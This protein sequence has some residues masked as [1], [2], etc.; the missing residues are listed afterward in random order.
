MGEIKS[1]WEIAREKAA[2]LGELSPEER[3]QQR[4]DRCS[5]IGKALAEQYLSQHDIQHLEA[6]FSKYN[7]EE[8]E[9]ITQA[10]LQRLTEALDLRYSLTLNTI[11]QGVLILIKTETV[12]ETIAKIR[13]LFQE[14]RETEEREKQE[15]ERTGM[16]ILH[17]LRISGT[18]ISQINIR[19]KEE[20][21]KKLLELAQPFNERLGKLKQELLT[22]IRPCTTS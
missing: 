19:A 8:R 21:Q 7:G 14:Y 9:L 2:K 13:E 10:V 1:A 4:E 6:E 20:W 18:A 11:S 15:I 22:S 5:S 12:A 3:K 17:Q 16:E